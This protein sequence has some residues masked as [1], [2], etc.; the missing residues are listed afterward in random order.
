MVR[1]CKENSLHVHLDLNI[2]RH[3][4]ANVQEVKVESSVCSDPLTIARCM[5]YEQG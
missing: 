1:I 5:R 2:A 4:A 3:S